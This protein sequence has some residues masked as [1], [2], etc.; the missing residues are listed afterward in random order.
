MILPLGINRLFPRKLRWS[1]KKWL[2]KNPR[3]LHAQLEAID[4][5]QGSQIVLDV[6]AYLGNFT[7]NILLSVPV[8]YVHCFE[9]NPEAFEQLKLKVGQLGTY[10][11]RNRVVVNN[12]GVGSE[13]GEEEL[14]ITSLQSASSFLP[15]AEAAKQ[16]WK[17][18][19]F[20]VRQ[21]T[22]VPVVTL[23][24]YAKERGVEKVKLLK[25]DAQGYELEILKGCGVLLQD[26]EY[27]F[28]EVQFN[29]LYEG[30]ATWRSIMKY[31]FEEGFRPINMGGFCLDEIGVP[32]QADMLLRNVRYDQS[33]GIQ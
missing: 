13:P 31:L 21:R 25:V 9:P 6:G 4:F 8:L 24:Q 20:S 10:K 16:G 30:A 15:V 14:I 18:A 19:D 3:H 22:T 5:S 2:G 29:P 32:L 27:I 23:E 1:I 7:T 17:N 11:G 28:I 33:A 12:C 26:I